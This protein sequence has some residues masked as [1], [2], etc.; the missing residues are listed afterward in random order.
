MEGPSEWGSR[1]EDGQFLVDCDVSQIPAGLEMSSQVPHSMYMRGSDRGWMARGPCPARLGSSFL[2]ALRIPGMI[3]LTLPY[4]RG[5]SLS[6]LWGLQ[7]G[8]G[9]VL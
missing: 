4:P 2:P 7:R 6:K 3:E 5:V 1:K 8:G 9:G